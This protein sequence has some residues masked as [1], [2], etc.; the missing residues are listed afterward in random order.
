[1][2]EPANTGGSDGLPIRTFTGLR[3]RRTVPANV[4]G[5]LSDRCAASGIGTPD[6]GS[7][8]AA[9]APHLYRV[10]EIAG[11]AR[12]ESLRDLAAEYGVSH[13]T[14]RTIVRR[15]SGCRAAA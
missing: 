3:R 12:Y 8:P 15:M 5:V 2:S 9:P 13:E 7:A 4:P 11:R 14:I 6:A 10:A 1:M